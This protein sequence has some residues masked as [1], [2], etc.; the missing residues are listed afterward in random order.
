MSIR[1][2]SNA[3]QSYGNYES[4]D[5]K[6]S[7]SRS[8]ASSTSSSKLEDE[9]N[10]SLPKQSKET[11]A[12]SKPLSGRVKSACTGSLKKLSNKFRRVVKS[13]IDS[14]DKV[15]MLW[16]KEQLSNVAKKV[17]RDVESYA[18]KPMKAAQDLR[19]TIAEQ[20]VKNRASNLQKA[21]KLQVDISHVQSTLNYL[22]RELTEVKAPPLQSEED[23]EIERIVYNAQQQLQSLNSQFLDVLA[24][25]EK[26]KSNSTNAH[27]LP[28]DKNILKLRSQLN[29]IDALI[30]KLA[31]APA[32][33]LN[34]VN[35]SMKS[36]INIK[37]FNRHLLAIHNDVSNLAKLPVSQ[38]RGTKSEESFGDTFSKFNQELGKIS[39]K[40]ETL[41]AEPLDIISDTKESREY[42]LVHLPQTIEIYQSRMSNF[43]NEL[44]SILKRL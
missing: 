43:Q 24:T 21:E 35:L 9:S 39:N 37:K 38:I 33:K 26:L 5:V 11:T 2:V 10:R 20:S 36:G 41:T 28:S 42:D 12:T 30:S 25:T 19:A 15:K 34:P 16:M 23:E 4:K 8:E 40:L 1:N 3:N 14:L 13:L 6:N 31:D 22:N 29:H 27:K 18:Y 17:G 44:S 7:E 32:L